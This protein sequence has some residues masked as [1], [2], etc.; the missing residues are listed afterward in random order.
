MP[1]LSVR[2]SVSVVGPD[3]RSPRVSF[4]SVDLAVVGRSPHS[5][6]VHEERVDLIGR[7]TEPLEWTRRTRCRPQ[8]AIGGRPEQALVS[9]FDFDDRRCPAPDLPRLCGIVTDGDIPSYEVATTIDAS[10]GDTARSLMSN[11]IEPTC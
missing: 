1:E 10:S 4:L 3:E 11:G 5:V 2:E 9:P 7:R 8:L 6:T